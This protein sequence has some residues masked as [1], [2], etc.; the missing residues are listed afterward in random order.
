[1][2]RIGKIARLPQKIRDQINENSTTVNT[3]SRSSTG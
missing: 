1:M 2:S 3:A